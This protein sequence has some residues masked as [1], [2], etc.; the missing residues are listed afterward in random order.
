M[1]IHELEK[2]LSPERLEHLKAKASDQNI[3]VE[4]LVQRVLEDTEDE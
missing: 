2:I 1:L 4:Y 3:S